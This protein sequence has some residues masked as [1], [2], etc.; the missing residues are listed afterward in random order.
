[1]KFKYTHLLNDMPKEER[2]RLI[3]Y[4]ME[5]HILHLEQAKIVMVRNHK[6]MIRE[7]DDWI[8]NIKN[9]LKKVS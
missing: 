7:M 8:K 6:R 2:E 1:M 4:E 3:P 9:S 5:K